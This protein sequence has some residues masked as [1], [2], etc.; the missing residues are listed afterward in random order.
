MCIAVVS[1]CNMASVIGLRVSVFWLVFLAPSSI[2]E[3]RKCFMGS[4]ELCSLLMNDIAEQY[5]VIVAGA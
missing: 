4:G 5:D 3:T 2:L 1:L